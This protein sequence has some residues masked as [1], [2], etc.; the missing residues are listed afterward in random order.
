MAGRSRVNREVQ[1]R[2]CG[3]LE[4]R[5]LRSTRLTGLPISVIT[6]NSIPSFVRRCFL[7]ITQLNPFFDV[8]RKVRST[9]AQIMIFLDRNIVF[10]QYSRIWPNLL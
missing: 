9:I 6:L 8:L 4:V 10:I 3:G 1:A 2:I 7:Y 5:L